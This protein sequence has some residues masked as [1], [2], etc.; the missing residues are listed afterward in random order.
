LE[1]GNLKQE[2]NIL[3]ARSLHM[4]TLIIGNDIFKRFKLKLN[5]GNRTLEMDGSG[6]LEFLYEKD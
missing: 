5:Y 1:I 3:L 2:C 6:T 4:G